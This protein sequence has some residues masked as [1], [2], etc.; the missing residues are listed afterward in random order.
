MAR[1][2]DAAILDWQRDACGG[3]TP[4]HPHLS[5][6]YEA[7]FGENRD[8]FAGASLLDLASHHGCWSLAALATGVRSVIGIEARLELVEAATESLGEYG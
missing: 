3:S 2:N 1:I 5:E 6:R 4:A 7:I 8:I